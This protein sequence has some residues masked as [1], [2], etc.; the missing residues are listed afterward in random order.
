MVSLCYRPIASHSIVPARAP[1]SHSVLFL[2]QRA[3]HPR[4]L[5]KGR[6]ARYR[7]T[8]SAHLRSRSG[9]WLSWPAST[10]RSMSLTAL[11][12]PPLGAG[13]SRALMPG[14]PTSAHSSSLSPCEAVLPA[15]WACGLDPM[16]RHTLHPSAP[17]ADSDTLMR[18][19]LHAEPFYRPQGAERWPCTGLSPS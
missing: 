19:S 13:L 7:S 18:P 9:E 14:K 2:R 16:P 3:A 10:P 4:P 17:M 1:S 11:S 8:A 12:A 6:A 15:L 5:G